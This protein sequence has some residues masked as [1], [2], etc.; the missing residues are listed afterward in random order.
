MP[1]WPEFIAAQSEIHDQLEKEEAQALESGL[2]IDP[3]THENKSAFNIILRPAQEVVSRLEILAQDVK[4]LIP[5]AVIH[6][7]DE[8]HATLARC[9]H[10]P[11]GSARCIQDMS[12]ASHLIEELL[13]LLP[14]FSCR[15]EGYV[16]GHTTLIIKGIPEPRY[17]DAANTLIKHPRAAGLGLRLSW[18]LH[19]TIARFSKN[20]DSATALRLRKLIS[21]PRFH[22]PSEKWFGFDDMRVAWF[23]ANRHE[24]RAKVF[25]RVPL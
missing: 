5:G 18:G 1:T 17:L 10:F 16:F 20:T 8:I 24:L 22:V 21:S 12:R 14:R 23:S 9:L 15:Y 4:E 3:L 7:R 2:R 13:P 11:E 25:H 6:P 19:S